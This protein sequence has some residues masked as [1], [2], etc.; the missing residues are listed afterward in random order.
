MSVAAGGVESL[1]KTLPFLTCLL[2]AGAAEAQVR[3]LVFTVTTGPSSS[4]PG[5]DTRPW[6]AYSDSGYGQRTRE[7]LGYGGVEQCFGV[8]ERLGAGFTLLGHVGLEIGDVDTRSSQQA[9]VPRRRG[10]R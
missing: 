8:Q 1:V 5:S 10:G 9:E 2:L 7:P 3:P 4:A 6:T